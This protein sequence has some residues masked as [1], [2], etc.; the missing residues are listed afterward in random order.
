MTPPPPLAKA[1]DICISFLIQSSP[2]SHDV[3]CASRQ[4]LCLDPHQ[5]TLMSVSVMHRIYEALNAET[6]APTR[7]ANEAPAA[8]VCRHRT[9]GGRGENRFWV[10]NETA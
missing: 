8:E 9:K 6:L 10:I 1:L 4:E 7:N 2:Y 3:N 5:K